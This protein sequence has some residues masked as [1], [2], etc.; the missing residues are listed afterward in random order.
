MR[1]E[2]TDADRAALAGH[3]GLLA[4]QVALAVSALLGLAGVCFGLASFGLLV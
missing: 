1:E 2:L 4:A 3:P